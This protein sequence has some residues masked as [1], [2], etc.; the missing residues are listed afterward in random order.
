MTKMKKRFSFVLAAASFLLFSCSSQESSL[1][2]VQTVEYHFADEMAG[3]D[4]QCALEENKTFSLSDGELVVLTAKLFFEG[5]DDTMFF[6]DG[7]PKIGQVGTVLS[8]AGGSESEMP[9]GTREYV[10]NRLQEKCQGKVSSLLLEEF[11]DETSISKRYLSSK[12]SLSFS[13]EEH[14]YITISIDG[15]QTKEGIYVHRVYWH[16]SSLYYLNLSWGISDREGNLLEHYD[17]DCHFAKSN[18]FGT[19]VVYFSSY[20]EYARSL[21]GQA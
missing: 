7:K 20:E 13:E 14:P 9:Y 3:I 6:R 8:F 11:L 2:D 21:G 18:L 4:S 15:E 1:S 19:E 16:D 5:K 12:E 17:V 10:I